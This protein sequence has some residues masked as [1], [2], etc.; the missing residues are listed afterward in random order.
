MKKYIALFILLCSL[1]AL[2]AG[3]NLVGNSGMILTPTARMLPDGH[4]RFGYGQLPWPYTYIEQGEH[5]ELFYHG[6]IAFLPFLELMFG[7]V[8]P[9]GREW[10]I[11]DRTASIRIQVL[12]E[13]EQKPALVIGTQ[14]PFG[15]VAQDWAQQMNTLY[16]V[17][18]KSFSLPYVKEVNVHYGHGV[19]WLNA[20]VHYLQGPFGGVEW[21]AVPHTSLLAEYDGNKINLGVRGEAYN[22]QLLLVWLDGKTFTGGFSYRFLLK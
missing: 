17:T 6:S 19:D 21:N 4:F 7:I 2:A 10:G 8:N 18:S 12:K 9:L 20:G 11:G 5:D 3:S 16:F 22:F 14:D 15:V 1:Q 13:S